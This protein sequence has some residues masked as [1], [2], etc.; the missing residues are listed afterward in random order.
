[1][2]KER[3]YTTVQHVCFHMDESLLLKSDNKALEILLRVTQFVGCL[4]F[5]FLYICFFSSSKS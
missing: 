3:Q 1:M 4:A 5:S 2:V